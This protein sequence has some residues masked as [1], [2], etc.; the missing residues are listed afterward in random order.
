MHLKL[1]QSWS[2]LIFMV[3][4]LSYFPWEKGVNMLLHVF[5]Q[6]AGHFAPCHLPLFLNLH[7]KFT[8]VIGLALTLTLNPNPKGLNPNP[9]S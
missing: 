1:C 7:S 9:K 6:N 3:A 5:Q 8:I 4:I 2:Y